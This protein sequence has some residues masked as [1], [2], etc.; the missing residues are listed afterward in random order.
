MEMYI[1]NFYHALYD[2]LKQALQPGNDAQLVGDGENLLHHEGEFH[3][4]LSV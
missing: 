3:C 1:L 4:T 2:P